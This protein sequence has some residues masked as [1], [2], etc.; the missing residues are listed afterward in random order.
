MYS[1]LRGIKRRYEE[2]KLKGKQAERQEVLRHERKDE[3]PEKLTAC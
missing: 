3:G 2:R 1:E